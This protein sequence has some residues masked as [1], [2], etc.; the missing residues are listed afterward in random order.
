MTT[1]NDPT[2]STHTPT[3]VSGSDQ[4]RELRDSIARILRWIRIR[5]V[6]KWGVVLAITLAVMIGVDA[7]MHFGVTIRLIMLG[8]LLAG[9]YFLYK[10][11]IAPALH[12]RMLPSD[13]AL[14]SPDEQLPISI[15][16]QLRTG[17]ATLAALIDLPP[18]DQS[19]QEL[20]PDERAIESSLSAAIQS[21]AL[22]SADTQSG[23]VSM[24][25]TPKLQML[26]LGLTLAV[27]LGAAIMIPSSVTIGV[28]RIA[29]PWSSIQWP[30]RFGITLPEIASFHPTDRAMVVGAQIG[31][32]TEGGSP[33]VRWRIVGP[34][35][36]QRSTII[37]WTSLALNKQGNRNQSSQADAH[38]WFEQLIPV[39]T[40]STT[41]IPDGSILEYQIQTRDDKSRTQR[42]MLVHP[43]KLVQ[44]SARTTL[45]AYALEAGLDQTSEP[46]DI[47]EPSG[48]AMSKSTFTSG[49]QSVLPDSLVLGPVLAGSTLE[50]EWQYDSPVRSDPNDAFGSVQTTH[51]LEQSATLRIAPTDTYG[52]SPRAPSTVYLQVLPDAA[53]DA[54][55][56]NP[57]SELVIGQRATVPIEANTQD[58]LGLVYASIT[59]TLI[60]DQKSTT[61]ELFAITPAQSLT[62]SMSWTLD[63][64]SAGAAPGDQILIRATA[65]DIKGLESFSAP[66]TIRIVEDRVIVDRI[67]AQLGSLGEVLRRLDDQQKELIT[68]AST[69]NQP[70]ARE[71]STLTDQIQA[72]AQNAQ[73]LLEQ[74][75]QS[76]I[77]DPRLMPTLRAVQES[78]EQAQESSE[79][80]E[81]SL[82]REQTD[83]AVDR[84]E[85]VRDE[86]GQAI[87][88]LDRGQDTWLARRSIE[89]LR[90][91]VQSVLDDTQQ[92]GQQ[93]GGRSVDQLS[94]D[95]RSTLQKILDKQRRIAQQ[96]RDTID[97]LDERAD[98]LEDKNPTGA[99]GIR[100]AATQGR[101]AGVEE[102]LSDAGDALE[103]NQTSSAAGNQ[104][105]VLDELDEMLEQIDE[106]QRN[107]DSALRRK[108]ASLMETI[109][110]LIEDQQLEITRLDQNQPMLDASLIALRSNTLSA[111]D[112]AATAFPE[113]R[114]IADSLTS[115]SDAQ[116][117]AI[118]ALRANPP[119]LANAR[120]QEL[121]AVVHL[122]NALD[123]AKQQD[124]MAADRQAEQLRKELRAK[125]QEALKAQSQITLETEPLI[126]DRLTRRQRAD[127]RQLAQQERTLK[128]ELQVMLDETAELAD[129]PIFTLAHDQIDLL[130][131]SIK[132]Q[133][134]SPAIT[135]STLLDQQ[136]VSTILS[137]LVEV[138]GDA[139]QDQSDDFEDGQAGGG[140]GQGGSGAQEPVIPPVAQLQLLK[141][142]QQLTATRT[143][144]LAETE[145]PDPARVRQIGE[146]QRELAEKG[147][148][149]IQSMNP[150]PPADEQ[151]IEPD[152]DPKP[153]T[154]PDPG[155]QP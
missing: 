153:D 59:S 37:Q 78:L 68:Q 131:E 70:S 141:S 138:L 86:L 110:S 77:D 8:S 45:P 107:R 66:R 127:A 65:R 28:P 52:L 143:R 41:S 136:G 100:D 90:S 54:I 92:L 123:E 27:V 23:H 130:L 49:F 134:A 101:N 137:A 124:E 147:I 3:Q 81:Q 120:Q 48:N 58:D 99:Q 42:V 55:I 73:S 114:N 113:T 60:R 71:Q 133:L 61:D 121:S 106:A 89:D 79:R 53:P 15:P 74:L 149:L 36:D 21:R 47:T 139:Q 20:A 13:L 46:A 75:A 22:N 122:E 152:S 62:E 76:K 43:P 33:T 39:Q 155:T 142:L 35:E 51:T 151:Q 150:D 129:A 64:Q 38:T 87:E 25:S 56:T 14:N 83:Q 34:A 9:G 30:K 67:D 135:E 12:I 26:L 94:E 63:M 95:E 4:L 85:D 7:L 117:G 93:T 111:R 103:Q 109:K 105:Q 19:T 115:A 126:G 2:R 119:E 1:L 84:M 6:M 10:R 112:D 96:A 108:L 82:Q 118:T 16:D 146:L 132:E 148:E 18:S 31:P 69:P 145:S 97:Q 5:A 44:I 128:D 17:S 57:T 29:A 50:L 40:V 11:W 116:A 102:Q 104:Q 24:G 88:Q 98:E 80:A 72:R 140:G 144:A 125:Y 32:A 91:Q 154:D